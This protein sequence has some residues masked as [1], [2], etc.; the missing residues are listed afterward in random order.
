MVQREIP[1]Q[2]D[3]SSTNYSKSEK[4][5]KEKTMGNTQMLSFYKSFYKNQKNVQADDLRK[6]LI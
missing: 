6:D 4:E 3:L 2:I 5:T 1:D